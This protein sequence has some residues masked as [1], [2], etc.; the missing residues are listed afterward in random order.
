MSGSIFRELTPEWLRLRFLHGVDL[1]D[2]NGL[3][4]PD[5]LYARSLANAVSWMES[6]LGIKI[7]SRPG[8]V[9]SHDGE[10]KDGEA[11][12]PFRLDE[13]PVQRVSRFEITYGAYP[14]AELPISWVKT[15][16]NR[17]G[18]IH[19]VPS[20]DNLDS[21]FVY[22]AGLPIIIGS[23]FQPRAYVP[24]YFQITYDAGF[25][26][27]N[28]NVTIAD[29]V[30]SSV[31]TFSNGFG[32][33]NAHYGVEASF[34][35]AQEDQN[36]AAGVYVTDKTKTGFTLN[37]DTAPSGGAVA[38]H[39]FASDMPA[40]MVHAVGLKAALVPLDVAGDLI[41]GAGIASKSISMDGLSMNINTTSSATNAGYGARVG[42]YEREL[43]ALMS[44]LR[45]RWQMTN[46]SMV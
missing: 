10:M 41:V 4:Y 23:V 3:P 12:W 24:G 13:R 37:L 7:E 22:V 18:Q 40:N 34:V 30:A 28:G 35:G 6:Q 31:V 36:G 15:V 16:S 45:K 11:W 29:G 33:S 38:L 26:F 8:V 20:Q 39:W 2:D 27:Q 44:S 14:A 32:F 25:C 5:G 43:K 21:S 46:I 42:Q 19:L 9:E 1:T 17:H